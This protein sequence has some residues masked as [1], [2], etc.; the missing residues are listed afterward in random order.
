M[1]GTTNATT[2][3]IS[4]TAP[5]SWLTRANIRRI[6]IL[7]SSALG[8]VI[9]VLPSLTA[10]KSIFPDAEV[11]WMV[12]PLGA[13]ILEGHPLIDRLIVFDRQQFMRCLRSPGR[14]F[15]ALRRFT[16][17]K[18]S[19]RQPRFD[20]V[21][22]F[23]GNYRSG[24]AQLIAGGRHRLSFHPQDCREFGGWLLSNVRARPAPMLVPKVL[25]NLHLV[26]EIGWTGDCPDEVIFVPPEDLEWADRFISTLDGTGPLIILHPAVSRFGLIKQWPIRYYRTLARRLEERG[27]RLLVSWGPFEREL[28][29]E[30]GAGTV[31]PSTERLFHLAA[32]IARCD[33]L[34]ASDT[35]CL[36]LATALGRRVVGIYGPK[37][38]EQYGP[39]PLRGSVVASHVPCSPCKLRSC[40]HRIC[41]E[42]IEPDRVY[43][44]VIDALSDFEDTGTVWA[45]SSH[46]PGRR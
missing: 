5:L 30:V 41:M 19:L 4:D 38:P 16:A 18:R 46:G 44:A 7:R 8:D 37:S 40:S 35:G 21:I 34:V 42:E 20:L 45:D 17:L 15:H 39:H 43:Q 6:L 3:E 31:A 29:E 33:L 10:L 26:R 14:W 12:E 36:H 1:N 23:Q 13:M 28:A 25:K 32:L 22:D 9:H 2:T 24:I 27:A 11:S